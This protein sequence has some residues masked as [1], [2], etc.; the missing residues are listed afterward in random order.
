MREGR[1]LGDEDSKKEVEFRYYV[2][3]ESFF[4]SRYLNFS[5]FCDVD[6]NLFF[7]N[8]FYFFYSLVFY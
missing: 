5:K 4:F 8:S 7:V 1:G 3:F 2:F 6:R